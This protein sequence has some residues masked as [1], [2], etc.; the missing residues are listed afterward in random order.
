MIPSLRIT[1]RR[2]QTFCIIG[3]SYYAE[4][5][6]IIIVTNYGHLFLI[7][8]FCN[9]T[10]TRTC[11]SYI[12]LSFSHNQTAGDITSNSPQIHKSN[13]CFVDYKNYHIL[14]KCYTMIQTIWTFLSASVGLYTRYVNTLNPSFW[15][16]MYTAKYT[17]IRNSILYNCSSQNNFYLRAGPGILPILVGPFHIAG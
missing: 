5:T 8:I 4:I 11:S 7:F 12:E 14:L 15:R 13:N 16:H 6:P 1:A 17:H 9:L 2:N 3:D 10:S